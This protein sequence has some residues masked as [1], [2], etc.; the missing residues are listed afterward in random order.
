[1]N[2]RALLSGAPPAVLQSV[3]CWMM[4]GV[5]VRVPIS[6]HFVPMRR[7]VRDVSLTQA[8]VTSN[9][10]AVHRDVAPVSLFLWIDAA[11][12]RTSEG[13]IAVVE[14][15][16]GWVDMFVFNTA[17]VT[18]APR[19][20]VP[21]GVDTLRMLILLR[22]PGSVPMMYPSV[23]LGSSLS[24]P[25]GAYGPATEVV[26]MV[27]KPVTT[28]GPPLKTLD[29]RITKALVHRNA[30]AELNILQPV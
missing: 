3:P 23:Q 4:V 16:A 20:G 1:M 18:F 28:I 17:K 8:V 10:R 9:D 13:S 30:P 14:P 29:F 11:N 7:E 27:E 15:E 22:K 26:A 24:T 21:P 5:V 19:V 2:P 6:Y 12:S 25:L